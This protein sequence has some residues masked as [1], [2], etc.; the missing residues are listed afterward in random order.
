MKH[1]EKEKAKSQGTSHNKRVQKLGKAFQNYRRAILH[2][3][4]TAIF[5]K[6]SLY[7]WRRGALASRK[8]EGRPLGKLQ[9]VSFAD[10]VWTEE[11][12]GTPAL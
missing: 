7:H 4:E 6:K 1:E 8:E 2:K 3:L 10:W 9:P 12:M 5:L 11:D